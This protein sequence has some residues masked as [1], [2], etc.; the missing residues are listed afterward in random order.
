MSAGYDLAG[1]GEDSECIVVGLLEFGHAVIERQAYTMPLQI[2]LYDARHLL[3]E[4][5]QNLIE[6]LNDGDIEP[7]MSEVLRRLETDE[8]A[9]YD[10]RAHLGPDRLESRVLVHSRE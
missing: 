4:R 9:T 1:F 6:H 3:I 5:R 8:P 2:A 7:S 10:Y